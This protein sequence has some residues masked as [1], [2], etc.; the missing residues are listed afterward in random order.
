ML[1]RET[2]H[3]LSQL[4]LP[5]DLKPGPYTVSLGLFDRSSSGERP[6]EFALNANHRESDGYYRVG[7]IEVE[8]NE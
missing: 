4:D 6:L 5:P 1:A 3:H 8:G 7:R 2:Y